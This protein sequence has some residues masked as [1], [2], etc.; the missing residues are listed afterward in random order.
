M[1]GRTGAPPI[2]FKA[3]LLRVDKST[4]V[5]LPERAS[6]A[7]PSRGQVA[8]DA[9]INGHPFETVVEPDGNSG[10][11]IRI[12]G[13]LQKAASVR[14]GERASLEIQPTKEWP[15]PEIPR[16]LERALAAGPQKIQEAWKDITPMARWEWVRWVNATGN[17]DTRKRRVEVSISKI[18]IGKRRPC[19]F[20]LA[21]CTDPSLSKNGKLVEAV[22]TSG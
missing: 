20:D 22:V 10:H 21:S 8:V 12:E 6:Q 5:R 16:D 15:E 1:S 9:T 4:I 3:E 13:T 7:L 2:R 14:A 19:C 11:W 17:P 18:K